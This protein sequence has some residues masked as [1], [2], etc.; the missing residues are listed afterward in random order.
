MDGGAKNEDVDHKCRPNSL[1]PEEAKTEI[2]NGNKKNTASLI[3]QGQKINGHLDVLRL[4]R[5]RSNVLIPGKFNT[6]SNIKTS[7]KTNII[8]NSPELRAAGHDS[9]SSS[10][11]SKRWSAFLTASSPA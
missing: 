6:V 7:A 11:P 2:T 3:N 10:S 8:D 5:W 9:S 1:V 4:N